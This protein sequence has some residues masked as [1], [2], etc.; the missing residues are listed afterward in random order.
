M[1]GLC[2]NK[3]AVK[4]NDLM[5]PR[6]CIMRNYEDFIATYIDDTN[7]T[8]PY[9]I[10]KKKQEALLAACDYEE[11]QYTDIAIDQKKRRQNQ[12]ARSDYECS[13]WRTDV[14]TEEDKICF[15]TRPLRRCAP[16]CNS[17]VIVTKE[18]AYHCQPKS[19]ESLEMQRRIQM[20]AN[21]D[22]SQRSVSI[23]KELQLP[24]VCRSL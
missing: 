12:S 15:S 22:L 16:G 9:E 5:A 6:G 2:G 23:V 11:H 21:P 20:G 8:C 18:I 10:K 14:K 17:D 7:D 24:T 19:V 1:R 13:V 3:D 4:E